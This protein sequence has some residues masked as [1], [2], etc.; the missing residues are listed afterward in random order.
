MQLRAGQNCRAAVREAPKVSAL[1]SIRPQQLRSH[2]IVQAASAPDTSFDSAAA[3][4]VSRR[5]LLAAAAAAAAVALSAATAL[6]A[7]ADDFTRTA[8]G[9]LYLDVREGEGAAPRPGDVVVVH[10]SGYT[11]GYQGKR[12]DNTSVR[13]EPYEFV[14][15]GDGAIKAFSEAVSTMK[16]GG[17]RRVEVPGDRPE[18][19]YPRDRSERF[20]DELVSAD[21]K[22]FKYRY[23][24]QPVELGGQRA[25]DFV[26]D[27]PTLQDFN[28]TLLFDIKL[29][30][31]RKAPR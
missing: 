25:L 28:R 18:L 9:L 23:G 30:T 14:L 29:L 4:D 31:V 19:A 3:D 24:P 26:L 11:K 16:V 7:Q 27:N 1:Q 5:Q 2:S 21:G 15:G 22:I 8:S 13:D 6:P 12:I 20:T 17:I 10:W